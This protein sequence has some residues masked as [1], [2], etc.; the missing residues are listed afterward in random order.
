MN[1]VLLQPIFFFSRLEYNYMRGFFDA[2]CE[3]EKENNKGVDQET[4]RHAHTP[5][6]KPIAKLSQIEITNSD[7]NNI[8][9]FPQFVKCSKGHF[10]HS[11]LSCLPKSSCDIAVAALSCKTRVTS[12]TK[13]GKFQ[14]ATTTIIDIAMFQCRQASSIYVHYMLVCDRIVHCPDGSDEQRCVFPETCP[15]GYTQCRNGQ[16]IANS[17]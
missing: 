1:F 8:E 6:T 5:K 12:L 9:Q 16:C 3:E 11:Y 4:S 2:V 7:K 15:D 13:L 14:Q 17:K 10:V